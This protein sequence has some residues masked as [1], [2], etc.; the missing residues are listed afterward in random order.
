MK[1]NKLNI[2]E[3]LDC[4]ET[5]IITGEDFGYIFKNK[6][7]SASFI[8]FYNMYSRGEVEYDVIERFLLENEDCINKENFILILAKNNIIQL[9]A[10]DETMK[11]NMESDDNKDLRKKFIAESVFRKRKLITEKSL[12]A[13]ITKWKGINTILPFYRYNEEEERYVIDVADS[14]ELIDGKH[15]SSSK[16]RKKLKKINEAF[17]EE[18]EET[19]D[20]GIEYILQVLNLNDF[21]QAFPNTDFHN[22]I[23]RLVYNRKISKEKGMSSKEADKYLISNKK[24]CYEIIDSMKYDNFSPYIRQVLE[25][26]IKYVDFDKLLMMAA[27]RL[28]NGLEQLKDEEQ[29]HGYEEII[30]IIASNIE[31][32]ERKVTFNLEYEVN[33]KELIGI[34]AENSYENIKRFLGRFVN[35]TYLS[36]ARIEE[37]RE[38]IDSKE[39]SLGDLPEGYVDVIF[40]PS[41]IEERIGLSEENFIFA[42]DKFNWNSSEV[43]ERIK[44]YNIKSTDFLTQLVSLEKLSSTDIANLYIDEVISIDEIN[45][46]AS[47]LDLS[48]FVNT[49]ELN[50]KY[51]DNLKNSK[52]ED[53][54]QYKRYIDLF[55]SVYIDGNSEEEKEK[56]SE[57]IIELII[58]NNPN[59]SKKIYIEALEH[60]YENGIIT[61]DSIIHWGEMLLDLDKEQIVTRL[62]TDGLVNVKDIKTLVVKKELDF[63]FF[64]KLVTSGDISDEIIL[65][66]VLEGLVDEKCIVNLYKQGKLTD[67]VIEQLA[68]QNIISPKKAKRL[69]DKVSEKE[70]QEAEWILGGDFEKVSS[71][72]DVDSSI[73]CE[74][75]ST[76]YEKTSRF[77]I[78][79]NQREKLFSLMGAYKK[80]NNINVNEENPFYNYDFYVIP[81]E[82]GIKGK[83]SI[84]I[85]E[86][87]YEDKSTQARFAV[88]NATYFFYYKDIPKVISGEYKNKEKALEDMESQRIIKHRVNHFIL[89]EQR[90]GHWALGVLFKTALMMSDDDEIFNKDK[91]AQ[92]EEALRIL[93]EKYSTD[94]LRELFEQ[95]EKIDNTNEC[96]CEILE[97]SGTELSSGEDEKSR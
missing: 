82:D 40:L 17:V 81:D 86:R 66:I 20:I 8:E 36:K 48:S 92:K 14:R 69:L 7:T 74:N 12:Q 18:D 22:C 29:T 93:L 41:E 84:V 80:A 88:D 23:T 91:P 55:K 37:Y 1:N 45:Q 13:I 56:I 94:E 65:S 24:E 15:V 90:N 33:G 4:L 75:N 42:I 67:E 19:R 50:E 27:C 21:K 87:I 16:N 47:I 95:Q 35:D 76:N 34:E 10:L 72:K 9:C 97:Y 73:Y 32:K 85:A 5:M 46:M 61:L 44:K 78:D 11:S 60:Y 31:D 38:K 58:E 71:E 54:Q 68:Q 3:I 43:V 57:E 83:N 28:E 52:Q 77:I 39:Q 63:D 59:N 49:N 26:Q 70:L 64:S 2:K 25:E 62:C 30:K 51:S 53:N 89:D 79:P 6:E 96:I